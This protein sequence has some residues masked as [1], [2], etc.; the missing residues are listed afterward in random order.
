MEEINYG[1]PIDMEVQT[2]QV[3]QPTETAPPNNMAT[4]SMVLGI[5]SIVCCC[6][7]CAG[8]ILGGLAV[9]FACLSKVGPTFESKAKTGLITGIIGM[10]LGVVSL[11]VWFMFMMLS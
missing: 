10:V 8:V 1:E 7:C 4:A 3:M 6:C 5:I 2:G 11:L 9:M